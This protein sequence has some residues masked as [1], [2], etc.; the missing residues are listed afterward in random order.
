MVFNSHQLV[1]NPEC[2]VVELF[3]IVGDED[4]RDAKAA[5]NALPY[6]ASDIHFSDSGQGFC[7]NPFSEVVNSYDKELK[8]QQ[9]G[10]VPLCQAS[11]KRMARVRSLG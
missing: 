7:L 11:T 6:E 10:R 4:S 3:S 1:E 9:W 2:V 5:N 8:L